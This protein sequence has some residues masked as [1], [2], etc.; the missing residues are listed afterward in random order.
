MTI[1]SVRRRVRRARCDAPSGTDYTA[2][3]TT[4]TFTGGGPNSQTVAVSTINDTVVEGTE[5]YAV[6]I[7]GQT[8]GTISTSQANTIISTTTPRC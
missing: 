6:T 1:W 4:L 5:D 8:A 3:G 2:L 7:G